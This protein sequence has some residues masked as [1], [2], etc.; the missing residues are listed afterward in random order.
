MGFAQARML[1]WLPCP[2]PGDLPDP[3]RNPRCMSP[4]LADGFF[5]TRTTWGA[6]EGPKPGSVFHCLSLEIVF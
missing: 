3:G 4:A 5:T 1:E 2:P 6:L